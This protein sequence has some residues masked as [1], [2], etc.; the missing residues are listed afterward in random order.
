MDAAALLGSSAWL[1]IG[2][3]VALM[4]LGFFVPRIVAKNRST[5]FGSGNSVR[6]S[7]RIGGAGKP[8]VGGSLLS[9]VGNVCSIV[10]L[11]IVLLQVFKILV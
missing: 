10:G 3:G 8:P 9:L 2:V 7:I 6:Q 4:L 5:I 11:V 1:V